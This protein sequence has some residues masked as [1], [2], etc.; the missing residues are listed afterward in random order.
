MKKSVLCALLVLCALFPPNAAWAED[1]SPPRISD[2][3][4]NALGFSFGWDISPV[5]IF[6]LHY[7][8]W[9]GDF[10]FAVNCGAMQ[11][12]N[13]EGSWGADAIAMLQYKFSDGNLTKNGDLYGALY[14]FLQS[15][16]VASYSPGFVPEDPAVTPTAP[17]FTQYIPV[18]VGIGIEATFFKHLSFPLELGFEYNILKPFPSFN[19][20]LSTC[21]RYRF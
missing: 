7:Q 6:N 15:G 10:G 20:C 9:L 17:R 21:I 14:G 4:P 16:Y 18:G 2:V 13:G 12:M 19:P 11:G 8:R 3:Y 5:S 1:E